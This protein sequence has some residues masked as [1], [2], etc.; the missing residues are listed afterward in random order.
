MKTFRTKK[1]QS[2]WK[3]TLLA[4]FALITLA[5]LVTILTRPKTKPVPSEA[6]AATYADKF[7]LAGFASPN[8]NAGNLAQY[9]KSLA[10]AG[11]K[12]MRVPLSWQIEQPNGP[13][14]SMGSFRQFAL[15]ARDPNGDG[16]L[17]DRIRILGNIG[18]TPPWAS[19]QACRQANPGKAIFCEPKSADEFATWA[20]KMAKYYS[21][22]IN[23]G[24]HDWEIWNEPNHGGFWVSERPKA[25][26]INPTLYA[27]MVIKSYTK[28]KA[29]D[30]DPTANVMIGGTS[31]AGEFTPDADASSIE[32]RS[33][34]MQLY[35][36]ARAQGKDLSDYYTAWSHHAYTWSGYNGSSL[37]DFNNQL[38]WYMMYR[39][40][41]ARIAY[42]ARGRPFDVITGSF[43]CPTPAAGAT[44]AQRATALSS[45][46]ADKRPSLRCI[47][48]V[49][50]AG[51]KKIWQSEAGSIQG[52]FTKNGDPINYTEQVQKDLIERAF[53]LWET[54]DWAGNYYVFRWSDG[55]PHPSTPYSVTDPETQLQQGILYIKND[56]AKEDSDPANAFGCNSSNA[57]TGRA[58]KAYCYIKAKMD[59][60]LPGGTAAPSVSLSVSD[61]TVTAGTQVTM[62]WT[63]SGNAT[64]CTGSGG[65]I[66]GWNGARAFANGTHT[67]NIN[68]GSTRTYTLE[69]TNS[70]GSTTAT[71]TVTVGVVPGVT[72]AAM[73]T[74][75]V[76]GGST[77]LTWS[78]TNSATSCTASGNWSGS[79]TVTGGSQTM[80]GIT[81]NKTYNL[82]C[83]ND[84]GSSTPL[85]TVS[86]TV[87]STPPPTINFTVSRDSLKPPETAV[88]TW[89]TS[90]ATSCTAN[91]SW[92][93]SKPTSGTL[94]VNPIDD[95]LYNLT[96]T[97]PGGNNSANTGIDVTPSLVQ[98]DIANPPNGDGVVNLDD[99]QFLL[100]TWGTNHTRS[101]L[102]GSGSV[103]WADLSLWTVYNRLANT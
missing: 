12:T 70:G 65:G 73:P 43:D 80:T 33:F 54:Y 92:T 3:K 75:V 38:G 56:L 13:N 32:P 28:M 91:G 25:D 55:Y 74:T 57:P 15:N 42:D 4:A 68:P 49:Y 2:I 77:T 64:S 53:D 97:G 60:P 81:T 22:E 17:N 61:D 71:K 62:T 8:G 35:E 69:C 9:P 88:L 10:R 24:I 31:P 89:S 51:G 41:T 46:S 40:V 99:F 98:G 90:G 103:D 59:D 94:T 16:N 63:V 58:K 85:A 82:V 23:G 34:M 26:S 20:G 101:D 18:Y 79:K 87:S 36:A 95:V 52:N 29:S 50:G 39:D 27:D 78:V 93:G 47:M 30:A 48:K 44:L 5:G 1:I 37:P 86:V 72:L 14:D 76:S 11:I 102:N 21:Q 67:L 19:T 96:C 66:T 84:F 7:G 100:F 6:V 45:L 83:A